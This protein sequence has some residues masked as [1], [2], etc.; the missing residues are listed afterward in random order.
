VEFSYYPGNGAAD[1]GGGIRVE[2]CSPTIAHCTVRYNR[3]D[4]SGGG[5]CIR[6]QNAARV[7]Y[8]LITGNYGP[9]GGGIACNGVPIYDH[10]VI[11]H[12]Y[13]GQGG[14]IG[15]WG[16]DPIIVNC[17]I[18]YNHGDDASGVRCS[19]SNPAIS[20]SII[21]FN[22]PGPALGLFDG[23]NN[24]EIA[25][26]NVYENEG[27]LTWGAEIPDFGNLVDLNHNDDSCDVYM[28]VFMEP[29]F[30]NAD[31]DDYHLFPFSPCV[32]AGDPG[33]SAD[34]DGTI[35]DIGALH[36]PAP[37]EPEFEGLHVVIHV[38]RGNAILNWNPVRLTHRGAA[39]YLIFWAAESDGPYF[40]RGWTYETTY[41]DA[42]IVDAANAMFYQV[43]AATGHLNL[44]KLERGM[45]MDDVM[46]RLGIK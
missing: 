44:T 23:S 18:A 37:S 16:A 22:G 1:G 11:T 13:A 17:T 39:R 24:A 15:C 41:T 4:Q 36:A 32:D 46:R 30:I 20:T 31:N 5:M 40:Y 38:T 33:L 45:Q 42:G 25:Y 10:C 6:M 34:S 3:C 8:C 12:N 35:R 14:G 28:N 2:A 29:F 19:G 26:S 27:G 7:S 21:A 9:Y 43:V